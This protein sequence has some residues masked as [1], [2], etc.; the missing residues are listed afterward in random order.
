V[1]DEIEFCECVKWFKIKLKDS[2]SIAKEEKCQ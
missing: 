2:E 1:C